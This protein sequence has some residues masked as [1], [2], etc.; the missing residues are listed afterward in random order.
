MSHQFETPTP[1]GP[2]NPT[3]WSEVWTAAVAQ[4][5]VKTYAQLSDHPDAS[6]GRAFIW[7]V[8]SAA[9]SYAFSLII[10]LV[11]GALDSTLLLLAL[12]CGFPIVAILVTVA[13]AINSGVTQLVARVLGGTGTYDQL[14]YVLAA[15]IAPLTI[16]TSVLSTLP[17][18]RFL[19]VALWIYGLVLN[20]ISVKAVH[21]FGWGRAIASSLA[22]TMVALFLAA[23]AAVFFLVLLGPG[24]EETF[25]DI[26]N[27]LLTPVP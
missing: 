1:P 25:G 16:F 23:C 20:V 4:P 7:I 21:R 24:I 27:Q 15:Y 14:T 8:A 10:E 18:L 9:I 26:A 6:S 3:S 13:F 5:S 17:V 12:V 2:E 22:I 11:V 19:N